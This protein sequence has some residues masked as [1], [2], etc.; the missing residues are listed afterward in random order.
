VNAPR[1][2]P[3][4]QAGTP[5]TYPGPSSVTQ[6]PFD[7]ESDAEPLHHQDNKVP[8]AIREGHP[9]ERQLSN[10]CSPSDQRSEGAL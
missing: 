9:E 10:V 6:R 7:H 5:Y 1:L 8:I 3:A 4:M 2:T